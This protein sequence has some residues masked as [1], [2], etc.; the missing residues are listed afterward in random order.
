MV[1]AECVSYL[2]KMEALVRGAE[3]L[4]ADSATTNSAKDTHKWDL[5]ALIAEM[6]DLV[7]FARKDVLNPGVRA[8]PGAKEAARACV[9]HYKN[10]LANQE[11]PRDTLVDYAV[12]SKLF[13]LTDPIRTKLTF[14]HA[15]ALSR[16]K[17]PEVRNAWAEQAIASGWSVARLQSEINAAGR[18][19]TES[20]WRESGFPKSGP[21]KEWSPTQNST[22]VC[23]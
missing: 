12:I 7:E 17:T 2:A 11:T 16:V 10:F 14:S 4:I 8:T 19:V 1:E 9:K 15:R 18:S 20:S 5:G 13:T 6:K 23:A 3:Q 22:W 21:P